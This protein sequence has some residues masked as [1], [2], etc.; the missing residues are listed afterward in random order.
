MWPTDHKFGSPPKFSSI[1]NFL[2]SVIG[3]DFCA[4]Y[5]VFHPLTEVRYACSV[6]PEQ[7]LPVL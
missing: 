7:L 5:K 1:L 3:P 4:Q 6:K 2:G